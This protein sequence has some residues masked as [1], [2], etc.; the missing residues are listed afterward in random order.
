ML[1]M[2]G[3]WIFKESKM[4]INQ[5]TALDTL[6]VS[7]LLVAWSSVNGDA[8][9]LSPSVLAALLQTLLATSDGKVTQYSAPSASGFTVV[10]ADNGESKWLILTPTAGF[11]AGTIKLPALANA[12]DKQEVVVN[13]TQAITALTIDGNGA[14]VTGEP[15]AMAANDFFR[16]RFDAVMDVWYRVG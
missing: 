16:L 5:L 14:T 10:L 13:C 6:M 2:M 12:L 7:D 9:K 11:A 1:A 8:R 3:G 15:A 4:N